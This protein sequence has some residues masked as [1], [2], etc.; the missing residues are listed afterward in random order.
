M[1]RCLLLT[2]HVAGVTL[3]QLRTH[4]SLTAVS[5][6]RMSTLTHNHTYPTEH[7]VAQMHAQVA[8]ILRLDIRQWLDNAHRVPTYAFYSVCTL[9]FLYCTLQYSVATRQARVQKRK[10]SFHLAPSAC[11]HQGGASAGQTRT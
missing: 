7:C 11:R 9:L 3:F 2:V 1:L 5:V 4:C 10:I 6:E 8:P